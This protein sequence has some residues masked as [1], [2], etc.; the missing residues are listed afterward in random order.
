MNIL[1]E[2][3]NNRMDIYMWTDI[4]TNKIYIDSVIDLSSILKN[5]YN[6]THL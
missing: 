6:I 3:N 5:Y 2:N 4:L 1:A